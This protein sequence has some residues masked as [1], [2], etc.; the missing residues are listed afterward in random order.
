MIV[1]CDNVGR[2]DHIMANINVLF[3]AQQDCRME[4]LKV[5]ILGDKSLS[6]LLKPGEHMILV[7]EELWSEKAYCSLIPVGRRCNHVTTSGL[8]WNLS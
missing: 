2:F 3:K 8:K 7:P 5:L 4:H 6:W 1:F